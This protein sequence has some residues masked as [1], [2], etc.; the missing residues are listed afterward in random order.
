MTLPGISS[1]FSGKHFRSSLTA[2]LV[3]FLLLKFGI[4]KEGFF[5]H[6]SLLYVMLHN[7]V[8]SSITI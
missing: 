3:W 2:T 8:K 7:I 5:R 4:D 6:K 1:L